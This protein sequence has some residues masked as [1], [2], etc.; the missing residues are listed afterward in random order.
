M[1]GSYGAGGD[2]FTLKGEIEAILRQIG[3]RAPSFEAVMD[4]PSYHPGRCASVVIDGVSVGCFGQVHPLAAENYGL[5]GE[6][7]AAELDFTAL[8]QLLAPDPVYTP[9]PK[10]PTITRDLALVCDDKIPV[11]ALEGCI[12]TS[13][14]KLLQKVDLF[15]IYRGAPIA[16][17]KKSVAFSLELRADDR[18]LTDAEADKVIQ[19]VLR[20][21]ETECQAVLR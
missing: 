1:L 8:N 10:Y 18:T 16:D 11:G 9:L 13:G 2:F 14:G 15:D 17:G 3:T 12:Q 21:L 20:A 7:Y 19:K 5:S 6:I 4:N